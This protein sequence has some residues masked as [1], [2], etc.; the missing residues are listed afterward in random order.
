MKPKR[1][2][3]RLHAE[4]M[5]TKEALAQALLDL[6]R[7]AGLRPVELARRAGWT[8]QFVSRLES[9]EGRLPDLTTIV[10]Y[11][12]ACGVEIGLVF[13]RAEERGLSVFSALTLQ[14]EL[15]ERWYEELYGQVI[16]AAN[17]RV[18]VVED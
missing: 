3:A 17:E 10:R 4:G 9:F 15:H 12:K 14:S 13:A 7:G 8:N 11:G 2:D 1:H 6:R 16:P 5:V 18:S